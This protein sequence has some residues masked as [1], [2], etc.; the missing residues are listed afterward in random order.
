MKRIAAIAS[1]MALCIL[2]AG[3]A[4]NT[5]S[6]TAL[7]ESE[8]SNA[9]ENPADYDGQTISIEGAVFAD[10]SSS[11]GKTVWLAYHDVENLSQPF[12]FT[13]PSEYSVTTGEYV[14]VEGTIAGEVSDI[15]N[16][17]VEELSHPLL[18]IDG[19]N[20]EVLNAWDGMSTSVNEGTVDHD[21]S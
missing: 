10:S 12:A 11:A 2:M 20:A 8:V 18:L 14:R 3:C 4:S 21:I 9:L 7:P 17:A 6:T 15:D 13:I 16:A 5:E 1:A 19:T